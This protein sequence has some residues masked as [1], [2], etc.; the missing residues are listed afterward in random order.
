MIRE[1]PRE[2]GITMVAWPLFW[3]CLEE[4]S[5]EEEG[6]P[7]HPFKY[8]VP[9]CALLDYTS[10][11]KRRNVISPIPSCTE[12]VWWLLVHLFIGSYLNWLASFGG[13]ISNAWDIG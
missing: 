3:A 9:F 5:W 2:F 12:T 10:Q 6:H 4:H 11:E 1:E 8:S 7:F 13:S